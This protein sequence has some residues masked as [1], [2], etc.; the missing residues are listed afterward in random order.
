M[1]LS[2]ATPTDLSESGNGPHL[3]SEEELALETHLLQIKLKSLQKRLIFISFQA[4]EFF[5]S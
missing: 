4:S 3:T 2:N 1:S 5:L